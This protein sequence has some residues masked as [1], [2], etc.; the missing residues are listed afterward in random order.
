MGIDRATLPSDL[1]LLHDRASAGD[2]QAQYELGLQYAAGVQV[3]RNCETAR[4]LWRS[5]STPTGGTMWIY[6][7][8]VGNGTTGRVI[9]INNGSPRPG[10]DVAREALANPALCPESEAIQR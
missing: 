3:P 5:A 8:P 6:S 4:S 9:P 10:M 2:Q 1:A 7:P